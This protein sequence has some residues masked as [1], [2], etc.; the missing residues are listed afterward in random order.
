MA[1]LS[2]TEA[3]ILQYLWDSPGKTVGEIWRGCSFSHG[4]INENTVTV[5]M[6]R[7]YG[8][9][10]VDRIGRRP[11]KYYPIWPRIQGVRDLSAKLDSLIASL[12]DVHKIIR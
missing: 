6:T 3:D 8:K 5:A 9:G 10:Y 1:S 2:A 11:K 4:D 7:L 12:E